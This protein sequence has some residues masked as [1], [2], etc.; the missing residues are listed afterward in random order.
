MLAVDSLDTPLDIPL[1]SIESYPSRRESL[2]ELKETK[3]NIIEFLKLSRCPVQRLL[4]QRNGSMGEQQTH[5]QR[6][7]YDLQFIT[8]G[9]DCLE[10]ISDDKLRAKLDAAISL[11][12]EQLGRSFWNAT[13]ASPELLYFA[14]GNRYDV[15][16]ARFQESIVALENLNEYAPRKLLADPVRLKNTQAL[17]SGFESQL[18][19]LQREKLLRTHL[20]LQK[21]ITRS[22]TSI[23]SRLAETRA[24]CPQRDP[25]RKQIALAVFQKFYIGE[26]QPLISRVSQ[27]GARVQNAL[28]SLV[29]SS[30]HSE[31]AYDRYWN[32]NWNEQTDSIW[33]SYNAAVLTHTKAWQK[34]LA[35][36]QVDVGQL[37]SP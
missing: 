12:R 25:K 18:Q 10:H 31:E 13:L 24:I 1:T 15:E 34:A 17:S 9:E 7:L 32:S 20:S 19:V 26:I 23:S 4:G 36:C 11:K 27:S 5:S 35:S 28:S 29:V 37:R 16:I 30:S 21:T 2:A 22:L 6:Y 33:S 8:L 14:G 3:I